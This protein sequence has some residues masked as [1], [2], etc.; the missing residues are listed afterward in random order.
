MFHHSGLLSLCLAFL[1]LL[2][3]DDKSVQLSWMEVTLVRE[4]IFMGKIVI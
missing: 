1:P 2:R 4:N 3:S